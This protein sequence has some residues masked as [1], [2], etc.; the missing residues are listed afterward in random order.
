MSV[1]EIYNERLMDLLGV[2]DDKKPKEL[3]I[4]LD[5]K[6]NPVPRALL[7]SRIQSVHSFPAGLQ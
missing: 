3:T 7:C 4:Q 2:G 1:T 5:K 6:G